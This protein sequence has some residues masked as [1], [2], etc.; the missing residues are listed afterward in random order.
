M[1]NFKGDLFATAVSFAGLA[2]LKLLSS[3]ILTRLLYPEAYGIIT[4]IASIA[5]VIEMISDVGVLGLM[6]RHERADE[7]VFI[8]TMWTLRLVRGAINAGIVFV[9]AP[10]LAGLYEEPALAEALRIFSVWF[11]IYA[12]ESM[13]FAL[14]I[15]RRNARVVSYSELACTVA[16]TLFVIVYSYFRRDWH[17]MVYGMVVNRALMLVASYGFYRSERPR[18]QFDRS[19]FDASMGY[20]KYVLPSSLLTLLVSQF[21]KFIFLKLFNIQLLGLYGLA[22]NIVSPIDSLVMRVSRAVLYPRCAENFRREPST[23]REKYYHE[24]VKLLLLI[25][26]LPSALAGSARLLVHVLFDPRYAYSA[27]IVEAFALRG[28]VAALA[29]PAEN[30]LVATGTPKPVL[31][32]NAMRAV[33]LLP[34][35]L[36]ANALWGFEG[37]LYVTALQGLP[38][39][40]YFLWLQRRRELL[41]ARYEAM[42]LGYMALVYL[43]TLLVCSQLMAIVPSLTIRGR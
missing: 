43:A 40:A 30:V 18:L 28:M 29:G 21:D 20:A 34:G 35:S 1:I 39:L 12:F 26:F 5:Y 9:L 24:N 31:L 10:L 42:K 36:I 38:A 27:V 41:I 16:S 25:L 17:G 7:P 6:I 8:N 15:R 22:G 19:V 32:A 23:V 11:L 33:W 14:A 13:S 4:M 37:F 3:V 2:V